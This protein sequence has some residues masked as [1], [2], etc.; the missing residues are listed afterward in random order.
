M[1]DFVCPNCGSSVFEDDKFCP[2]CG[3]RLID[4]RDYDDAQLSSRKMKSKKKKKKSSPL[5]R[6]I[7]WA[8]VIALVLWGIMEYR[9]YDY[10]INLHNARYYTSESAQHLDSAGV[11]ALNVWNN[12]I[13]MNP[14]EETDK[15]TRSN[16]G[17]GV[18]LSNI[19]DAFKVLMDDKAYKD[20]ISQAEEA[21]TEAYNLMAK[22]TNPPK[23]YEE[24]YRDMKTYYSKYMEFFHVVYNP[25]GKYEE[26]REEYMRVRDE[27]IQSSYAVSMY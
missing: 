16:D 19:E 13:H 14:D 1:N 4:N 17:S 27:F 25:V 2:E 11:L 26:Y 21:Q 3:T 24:A 6:I 8:V 15:Y 23:R 12:L 18:F 5:R 20:E 22:L 7:I 10:G 9:A